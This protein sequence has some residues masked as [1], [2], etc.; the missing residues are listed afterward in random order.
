MT[1]T[2]QHIQHNI[3]LIYL[4]EEN[5]KIQLK[6][7]K[8]KTP[9]TF[10]LSKLLLCKVISISTGHIER[11]VIIPGRC[12]SFNQYVRIQAKITAALIIVIIIIIINMYYLIHS[13]CNQQSSNHCTKI[14]KKTLAYWDKSY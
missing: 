1:R 14:K 6:I 2:V 7:I 4:V 9:H 3:I 13:D 10:A 5:N 12:I 11:V 8:T